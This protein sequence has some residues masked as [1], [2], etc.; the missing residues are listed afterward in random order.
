M[1]YYYDCYG[2]SRNISHI[3]PGREEKEEKG[4]VQVLDEQ[5]DDAAAATVVHQQ[6]PQ[7]GKGTSHVA[8]RFGWRAIS[9]D[10]KDLILK[11]Q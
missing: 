1:H 11:A 8:A 7:D 5:Y 6:S 10:S 2:S 4:L 9:K 3:H